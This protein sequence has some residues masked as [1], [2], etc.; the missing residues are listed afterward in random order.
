MELL[1]LGEGFFLF[2]FI[3]GVG[4]GLVTQC[5]NESR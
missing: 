4:L 5:N 2:F 1:R 3:L